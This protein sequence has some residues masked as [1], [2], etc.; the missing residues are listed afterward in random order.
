MKA[1]GGL[2]HAVQ[3][4]CSELDVTLL[5]PKHRLSLSLDGDTPEERME[6]LIHKCNSLFEV[7]VASDSKPMPITLTRRFVSWFIQVFSTELSPL[8]MRRVLERVM[9][10]K[11]HS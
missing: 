4:Y 2:L 5:F 10:K 1:L 3:P 6:E 11:Y 7:V 8:L 9:K